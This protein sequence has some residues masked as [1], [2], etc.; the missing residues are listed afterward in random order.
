MGGIWLAY[1]AWQL[2]QMPI[3]PVH[4]QRMEGSAHHVVEHG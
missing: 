4:D 3:L 2:Q 1:F